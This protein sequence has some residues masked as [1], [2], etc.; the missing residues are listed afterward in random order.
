MWSNFC[1]CSWSRW[2][3]RAA[4]GDFVS[5]IKPPVIEFL[6]RGT[7]VDW[8]VAVPAWG[9]RISAASDARRRESGWEFRTRKLRCSAIFFTVVLNLNVLTKRL[10]V[11]FYHCVSL[12]TNRLPLDPANMQVANTPREGPGKLPARNGGGKNQHFPAVG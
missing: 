9:G 2:V 7:Y 11:W 6:C 1:L 4:S 12:N 10:S 3:C 5:E 8:S